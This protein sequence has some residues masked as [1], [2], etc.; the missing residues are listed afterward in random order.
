MPYTP[1]SHRSPAS[2]TSTSP[3]VSRR[4]SFQNGSNRPSLPHSS[5]YLSKHRRSPSVTSLGSDAS[6]A[7]TAVQ[8]RNGLTVAIGSSVRQSPPPVTDNRA[9]PTGAVIS[10]PESNAS[11]SDDDEPSKSRQ[12]KETKLQDLRIA[13]S[14]MSQGTPTNATATAKVQA[15]EVLQVPNSAMKISFSTSALPE[16]S[17]QGG[18]R[19][20]HVRSATVPDAVVSLSADNSFTTVSDGSEEDLTYKPQMVRK[21]SGELV[22]PALRSANRRRPLSMPGTPVFSKAVHFDSHLEHIRHFLQVDRPLAV[23]AGSSPVETYDSESEYP[24]PGSEKA[25]SRSPPFEWELMTTNFPS[26]HNLIRRSLP[27]R[28]EKV[29]LSKD[30][31]SLMGSIAVANLAFEKAVTC[32]FT[33]DNWTTTS[34]VAA[35]FSQAIHPQE[36]SV[37]HDRFTFSIQLSDMANLECKTL[38][39]CVRYTVNG[40]EYWDN[41]GSANFQADFTKKHLPQKGKKNFQGASAKPM[42]GLP[43]SNR[44]QNPSTVPRPLS[45]PVSFNDFGEQ[46]AFKLD[47]P[48]HEY[49]GETASTTLRLRSKS[50]GNLIASDNIAKSLTSPSGVAF[51]NRYDFGA[52]LTAAVNASKVETPKD[53]DKDAL[54]MKGNVRGESPVFGS[55]ANLGQQTIVLPGPNT[56]MANSS[57]EEIV[58]KY[59]FVRTPGSTSTT[60]TSVLHYSLTTTERLTTS[61]LATSF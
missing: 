8:E 27:V 58:N 21:K 11:G 33:L 35:E 40:Q 48:I 18:R 3:D 31:K 56:T 44:R 5:S 9:M 26:Q 51:S 37:G 7:D 22:R 49:L 43:R 38:Y 29:W 53:K 54:Y 41:N 32:R 17:T 55:S 2:S 28:V 34:E 45:M 13:V 59:C 52:S 16:L 60:T 39:F 20:G 6:L 1:P 46:S 30:Q 4:S 50:S 12:D 47:Q 15:V 23:S 24:F 10:P 25:G 14:K 42:N 19:V 36:T 61:Q 57:Y